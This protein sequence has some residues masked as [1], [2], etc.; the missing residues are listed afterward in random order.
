[1]DFESIHLR[2]IYTVHLLENL[3]RPLLKK[4]FSLVLNA[5][6]VNN[7]DPDFTTVVDDLGG[8][9][10]LVVDSLEKKR[11]FTIQKFVLDMHTDVFSTV[12]GL[13]TNNGGK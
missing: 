9:V 4:K 10:N 12:K 6:G 1:M 8:T 13:R 11:M 3:V 5:V 2:N 7:H